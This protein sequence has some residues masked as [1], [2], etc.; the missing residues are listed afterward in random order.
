MAHKIRN[1]EKYAKKKLNWKWN[2]LNLHSSLLLNIKGLLYIVVLVKATAAAIP[3]CV[4][5][6]M[7]I[8]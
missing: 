3:L 6:T 4:L 5:E 1:I 8:I 2:Q 7:W